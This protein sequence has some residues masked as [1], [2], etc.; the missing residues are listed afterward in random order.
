MRYI[1]SQVYYL[2]FHTYNTLWF[3]WLS[4]IVSFSTTLPLGFA[5]CSHSPH[6]EFHRITGKSNEDLDKVSSSSSFS[7]MIVF[8]CSLKT[9]CD[10]AVEYDSISSRSCRIPGYMPVMGPASRS[11]IFST[12]AMY[13]YKY[14]WCF[15]MNVLKGFVYV[16]A[17]WFSSEATHYRPL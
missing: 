1:S 2:V 9:W 12:A 14:V 16:L 15:R 17:G 10:G 13:V 5:L 11:W 7:I 3:Y 6:D 4:V 8:L